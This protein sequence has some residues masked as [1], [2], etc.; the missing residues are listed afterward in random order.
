MKHIVVF[1]TETTGLPLHAKAPLH[2]QPKI[3]ELGAVLLSGETGKI[4]DE[5]SQLIHP[6]EEI[7][8][9]I[10]KI[11]GITNA[12][13]VG[14]PRFLDVLPTLH[15]FF[16]QADTVFCHNV[17]FDKK[18]L[19]FELAR[20]AVTN[21]P[22]PEREF[23]TVELYQREWGRRPKMLEL[24]EKVLGRPLQ[25]SHRAVEDCRALVEIIQA[26]RLWEL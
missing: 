7:S 17:T 6:G 21:F 22:W 12:Q 10:T 25:Q 18:L 1:D 16:W 2:K 5:F 15:K 20:A 11:T 8:A 19:H 13:L 3:I 24:Y 26:E 14:Q 4:L 23:C 9:E